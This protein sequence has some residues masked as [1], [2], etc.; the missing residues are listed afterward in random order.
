MAVAIYC[1][2]ESSDEYLYV[3]DG[4]PSHE[5]IISHVKEKMGDEYDYISSYR[6]EAT[7][8]PETRFKFDFGENR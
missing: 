8:Q 5:E 1:K 2:T 7:F 4:Q 3:F 6:Y